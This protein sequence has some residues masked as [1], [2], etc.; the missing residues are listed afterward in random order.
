MNNRVAGNEN[1]APEPMSPSVTEGT[2]IYDAAGD[3]VGVV[4]GPT[5]THNYI[6]AQK[7]WL[8]PKDIYIPLGAIRSAGPNGVYLTLS[9]DELKDER[10]QNRPV[11]GT[12]VAAAG[13]PGMG[14]E[15]ELKIPLVEEQLVAGRQRELEGQV[16]VHKNVVEQHE[17]IT[18]PVTH[19]EVVVEREPVEGRMAA[20]VGPN[21]FKERDINIPVY[22]EK[23]VPEK[24]SE[25]VE[26]V[27][28][29]KQPV[30]EEGHVSGTVRRESVEVDG[31]P[32][33]IRREG[34]PG[35]PPATPREEERFRE[36][37][38]PNP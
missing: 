15:R 38:R 17:T 11:A 9:K 34:Q 31:N 16:Q 18:A 6:V 1:V 19:E 35:R 8:F 30:T 13:R 23:L 5:G 37:R 21:A 22:G 32:D 25:V 36:N 27:V 20:D 4:G 28:V 26:D 7:G 33:L 12:E 2:P 3:K 24:R 29:G 10:Y 14:A